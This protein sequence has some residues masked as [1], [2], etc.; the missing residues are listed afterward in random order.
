MRRLILA[1]L[2]TSMLLVL[3]LAP[4]TASAHSG[5][6]SYLYVSV[7]D[8]GVKGRVE[9]PL[10]DLGPA[11]GIEFSTLPEALKAEIAASEQAIE[12]YIIE[13]T[14]LGTASERW[15]IEY[16][17]MSLLPT[18]KGAYVVLEFVV[19]EDFDSAPRTFVAD[20]SVIVESNPER[21]SLLLIEDDWESATFNNGSGPLL[22]FSVG[23]TQQVVD[24][25]SKSTLTSM[26][27]IR[28]IGSD[29]VRAGIDLLMIAAAL[30]SVM[31]LVPSRRNESEPMPL[32][33]VLRRSARGA[34]V[35]AAG[36]TITLWASGLG[37]LVPSARIAGLIVAATLAI[38]AVYLSA[39]RFVPGVRSF[40]TALSSIAGLGFGVGL[41]ATFIAQD[42]DRSRPV[43]GL[44]AF[45]FG[46]L[47]AA[48]LVAVF[49]G[50]P[51]LLLRRTRY[52]P[53][54]ILVLSLV[55]LGFAGLWF[56]ELLTNSTWPIERLANPLRVWPRNF[57]FVVLAAA[58][59]GGVRAIEQ[60]AGRLRPDA[61]D[62]VSTP[63]SIDAP[64][65]KVPT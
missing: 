10:V 28:G 53:G 33:T 54:V 42:L 17:D 18:S 38:V 5:K 55:L 22:G 51:L 14:A 29:A 23:Q 40:A 4:A 43:T 63:E 3:G 62:G 8:D 11:L 48:L 47:V 26:A 57:L 56:G 16:G 35:F 12:D 27:A 31:I 39:A 24:L 37:I 20:F 6:Q 30:A 49:I 36:V 60:R 19:D 65:E 9:I 44:I 64:G 58:V 21:D 34:G 15:T 50:T 45:Q 61:T 32:S 41:G 7:F 2:L 1:S 46:A 25:E 52:V 13:N 59:A